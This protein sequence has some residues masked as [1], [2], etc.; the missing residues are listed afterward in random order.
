MRRIPI[1]LLML[2]LAWS[3]FACSNDEND[4]D[5]NNDDPSTGDD[6]TTE[7]PDYIDPWNE[8]L[9]IATVRI[10]TPQPG[11]IVD[12]DQVVVQGTV[13]G[14]DTEEILINGESAP[15]NNGAFSATV[16]FADG[17]TVLPIY[18]ATSPRASVFGAE[19]IVAYRGQLA[20]ADEVVPDALLLALGNDAL[21]VVGALVGELLRDIDLMPALEG[22]NPV[23]D[24]D[25]LTVVITSAAIGGA[26]F[27]GAFLNGGAGFSAS[28]TDVVLGLEVTIGSLP[29]AIEMT[30]G[31]F[32][33]DGLVDLLL[34]D[35]DAQVRINVLDISHSDV[36]ATGALPANVIDLLLGVVEGVIENLVAG[37]LPDALEGIL[38][39]LN[40]KTTLIGFDLELGLSSM[41]VAAGGLVAGF[42]INAAL[43]DPPADLPWPRASLRTPNA[44]PNIIGNR[45]SEAQRF[46]V[47]A[48]VSDDLLNRVMLGVADSGLLNLAIGGPG[49][50]DDVI[51]LPLDAGTLALLFSTFGSID[52]TTE[53]S[54]V[55]TV[56]AVPVAVPRN[57]G[58]LTLRVPDY[59][60]EVFLHPTGSDPWRAMEISLDLAFALDA[61]PAE[62]GAL[63]IALPALSMDYGFIE[64]PLGETAP[65]IEFLAGWLP[66]LLGGLL[67]AVL[68][69]LPI[70]IPDIAGVGVDVL[71]W[72]TMGPGQ[73][74]WTAYFGLDYTPAEPE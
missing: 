47:G 51:E 38:T 12:A 74:Y 65:L 34:N 55:L 42:D 25:A 9:D 26:T 57:D 2:V 67:N 36:T 33:I 61:N 11:V 49:T 17:Q 14:S 18:A 41:D 22:L 69:E 8:D 60:L 43:T 39:S 4:D 31:A 16:E 48:A 71:A 23:V 37:M 64:N 70:A 54:L 52:P 58:S 62:G 24:S 10:V 5:E 13:A 73:D 7:E 63:S 72:D 19:K 32:N 68:A 40:I 15:V 29:L 45:P 28:L 20:P 46:G 27:E 3:V 66:E 56:G 44:A 50:H 1:F 59:R 6:D 53:A 35:G 30:I 21:D